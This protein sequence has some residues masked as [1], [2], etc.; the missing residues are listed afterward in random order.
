MRRFFLVVTSA[1]A[2]AQGNRMVLGAL[3]SR[4]RG[5]DEKMPDRG[6]RDDR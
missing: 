6:S 5:N 2:G 1:K 3:D 4:V